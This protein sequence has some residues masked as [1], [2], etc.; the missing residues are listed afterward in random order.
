MIRKL[1]HNKV[2]RYA[3]A[4]GLAT[5]VDVIAYY[6]S[7]HFILQKT[8]LQ[9]FDDALTVSAPIASLGISYTCGLITNFTVTKLFVFKESNLRTRHQFLRYIL[10]AIAVLIL[11]YIAM[12]FFVFVLNWYPTLSRII[13]ALGVGMLSYL[14]HKYYSFSSKPDQSM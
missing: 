4:A 12:K 14:S 2:M 9:F 3:F 11:N 13:S 1:Y 7:F 5:F 10:V 8:D 6:I